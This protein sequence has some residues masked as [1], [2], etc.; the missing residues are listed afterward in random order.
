M[1]D[2]ILIY[3]IGFIA[4]TLFFTRTI[5][6]WIKSE[7]AK[8]VVSPSIFWI[9]SIAGSYLESIYG[10]L[11]NDFSIILGQVISYYFYLWNLSLKGVWKRIHLILKGL[12]ILTPI[13][14][15]IFILL[16]AHSFVDNFLKN[17]KIPI[18]LVIL[19]SVGQVTFTVRFIYQGIYSYLHKESVLPTGFWIISLIGSFIIFIYAI[20]RRDPVLFL[21]QSCGFGIYIR[22]LVIGYKHSQAIRHELQINPIDKSAPAYQ[23]L[24]SSHHPPCK[25]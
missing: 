21:S 4:Q 7:K 22:N 20:I 17:N 1:K 16:D 13:I 24:T 11:R 12:L 6:Q 25:Q 23:V 15:G 10:W 3:G 18:W 9:Y 19:G 8:K 5:Y 14:A 2:N